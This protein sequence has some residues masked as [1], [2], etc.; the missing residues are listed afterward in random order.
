[1]FRLL[2]AEDEY[3]ERVAMK[4]IISKKFE[5]EYE[6]LEA[7]NG[8]E[9]IEIAKANRP[10]A[11]F[12]DIKMPGCSGIE[13]AKKIRES[14][15]DVIIVFVTAYDYFD[16]AKEAIS[17]KAEEMLLKPVKI[18]SVLELVGKITNQLNAK[19]DAKYNH[20][21]EQDF[22]VI[23]RRFQIEFIE[24]MANHNLSEKSLENWLGLMDIEFNGGIIALIEFDTIIEY[25][26][27]NRIQNE[28]IQQRFLEKLDNLSSKAGFNI[29]AGK[30]SKKMPIVFVKNNKEYIDAEQITTIIN[31]VL[32]HMKVHLK[33]SISNVVMECNKLPEAF[34]KINKAVRKEGNIT[35]SYPYELENSII[36]C[37][38][39][40]DFLLCKKYLIE[41][42]TQLSENY[43]ENEFTRAIVELYSVMK[44]AILKISYDALMDYADS[45]IEEIHEK[46][47]I[48]EFFHKLIDNTK[49]YCEENA[50]TNKLLVQKVCSYVKENYILDI[51]LEEAAEMIGYSSF[52]FA[53]LMREYFDMSFIDYLTSVRINKAEELLKTTDLTV[54]EIGYKVGYNDAN[55]FTR[56]FKRTVG[57]TPTQFKRKH[58]ENE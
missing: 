49:L 14:M 40:R 48:I 56:V 21:R 39:K 55:Y 43:E 34:Y 6:I 19:L 20:K 50:D 18:E 3:I 9:A 41:I 26:S 52:Y 16:Y 58:K 30:L 4:K 44:R 17:I 29:I 8:I 10:D 35:A 2:L 31:E 38:T 53:K 47:K 1:M 7:S 36:E 42:I 25:T 37:I 23:T 51:S 15:P 46:E 33:Y 5:E 11:I 13:A 24:S 22:D 57:T 32:K 27:A 54:S 28:F 12:L 45:I